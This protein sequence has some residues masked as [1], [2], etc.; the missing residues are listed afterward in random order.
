VAPT[1]PRES[2]AVNSYRVSTDSLAQC[3]IPTTLLLGSETGG[4]LRD[5]LQFLSTAIPGCRLLILQGQGH[6]AMLEGPDLFVRTVSEVARQAS[7]AQ[8]G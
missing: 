2:R 6:G 3:T 7:S 4:P 8:R 5:G 1:L